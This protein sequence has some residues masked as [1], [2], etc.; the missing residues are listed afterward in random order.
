VKPLDDE[1]VLMVNSLANMCGGTLAGYYAKFKDRMGFNACH[2]REIG[3]YA[4]KDERFRRHVPGIF[5]LLRDD[6]REAYIVIMERLKD[7]VLM[8]SANDPSGWTQ[9][10]VE[11]VLRGIAQVHSIWLGREEELLAQEWLGP[12][13]TASDM[14]EMTGLWESLKIHATEEFPEQLTRRDLQ[15][16]LKIVRS[17]DSWWPELEAMPRTLIHN[18]FNPRNVALR[19]DGDGHRLCAYDWELSTLQVPQHDVAEF[20]CFTLPLDATRADLE[21]YVDV[22]RRALQEASGQELDPA[23]CFR[24]FELSAYD[25]LVNRFALYMMAHTFRQYPF[26]EHV[27]ARTRHL[28]ERIRKG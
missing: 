1:V 11:T 6:K 20:L 24:A 27:T 4:Q 19:P 26:M 3:V 8:D 14:V 28:I 16:Y 23:M 12:V 22:H 2:R 10:H 17:L 25:L 18:D 9:A 13:M 15:F 7:M 5:G 21:H